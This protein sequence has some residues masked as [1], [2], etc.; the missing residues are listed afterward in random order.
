MANLARVL[1]A[2]GLLVAG[3]GLDTHHLPLPAAPF[4]LEEY[5][6]WCEAAGLRLHQRFAGWDRAAWH[7]GG[8][9]VSV[10]RRA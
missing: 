6:G 4:S 9:A 8:Y 2:G 3:F 1:T 10:H 5:D 7:G